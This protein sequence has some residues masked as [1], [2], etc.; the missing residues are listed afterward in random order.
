MD[1]YSPPSRKPLRG[2]P[3]PATAKEKIL[4]RFMKHYLTSSDPAYDSLANAQNLITSAQEPPSP[5]KTVVYC[6]STSCRETRCLLKKQLLSIDYFDLFESA[7]ESELQT[8]YAVSI[9]VK[10]ATRKKHEKKYPI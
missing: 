4:E 2:A 5:S 10:V 3:S 9:M 6:N 8:P 1:S 7:H